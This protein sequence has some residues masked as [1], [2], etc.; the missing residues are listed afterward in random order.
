MANFVSYLRVSTQSQGQHGLGMQAQRDAVTR[1]V[2]SVDGTI[3]QEF[4]EVESGGKGERP[5][6]KAALKLCKTKHATL[7]IAKLDRLARNVR[8][9]SDLMESGIDFV[10]ADMPSANRLTIHIIAAIA[11]HERTMISDRTRAGLKAA[12]ARGIKLGNPNWRAAQN[13]A[14]T[15]AK[16]GAAAFMAKMKPIVEMIDPTG[17]M[18]PSHL[19]SILD[20]LGHKPI[21]ASSWTQS[22]IISLRRRI[23]ASGG[24]SGIC[25]D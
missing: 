6:L 4:A 21:R 15:A 25:F 12:K 8:F 22:S 16:G 11:E 14:T 7:V 19:A 24:A 3:L 18:A 5:Q 10:A 20:R 9:I 13:L 1:Y 17:S 23:S 2:E